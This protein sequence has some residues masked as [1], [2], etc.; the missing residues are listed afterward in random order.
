MASQPVFVASE[1]AVKYFNYWALPCA[2]G[3]RC[4][5]KGFFFVQLDRYGAMFW[6][7]DVPIF[8]IWIQGKM[9]RKVARKVFDM[10]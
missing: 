5:T 2:K 1:I 7:V 4:E 6:I 9:V 8:D 10:F 3:E